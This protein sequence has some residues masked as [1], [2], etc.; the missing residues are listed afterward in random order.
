MRKHASGFL[1]RNG[2]VSLTGARELERVLGT[3]RSRR[4]VLD[5]TLFSGADAAACGI[6]G[7][8]TR[9]DEVLN[10]SIGM[11]MR[12]AARPM[13]GEAKLALAARDRPELLRSHEYAAEYQASRS[14]ARARITTKNSEER[15]RV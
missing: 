2:M 6:V 13:F 8:L 1:M 4:L 10:A 3:A 14:L 5:G 15:P 12:L 11:A 9:D 7:T